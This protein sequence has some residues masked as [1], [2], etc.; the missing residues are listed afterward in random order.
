[1]TETRGSYVPSPTQVQPPA[2][3]SKVENKSL[4]DFFERELKVG[5]VVAFME[6]SGNSI[7]LNKGEVTGFTPKMVKL[8]YFSTVYKT[9]QETKRAPYLIVKS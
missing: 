4:K 8:K 7:Y 9:P 6:S 2:P 5:D 1:M 3:P